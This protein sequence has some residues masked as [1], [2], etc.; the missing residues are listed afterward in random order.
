MKFNSSVFAPPDKNNPWSPMQITPTKKQSHEVQAK[1]QRGIFIKT[2]IYLVFTILLTF[3]AAPILIEKIIDVPVVQDVRIIMIPAIFI[4]LIAAIIKYAKLA[5]AKE[6]CAYAE[7]M[8][9]SIQ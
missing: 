5:K 1:L 8:V 2:A 6:I 7:K 9:F 3:F 4:G